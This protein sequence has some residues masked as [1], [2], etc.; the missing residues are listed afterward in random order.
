MIEVAHPLFLRLE[1]V[2]K[3][4]LLLVLSLL[5]SEIVNKVLRAILTKQD[6]RL[7]VVLS[8]TTR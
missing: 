8:L 3:A 5:V 2:R 4:N 7:E 1:L 6:K